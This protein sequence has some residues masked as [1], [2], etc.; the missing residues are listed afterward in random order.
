MDDRCRGPYV[1]RMFTH[2]GRTTQERNNGGEGRRRERGGKGKDRK[3]RSETQ[4]YTSGRS[5]V[6]ERKDEVAL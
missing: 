5:L 4:K 2:E 6:T 1:P 3:I